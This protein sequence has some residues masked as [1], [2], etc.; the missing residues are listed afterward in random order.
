MNRRVPH[1]Y[2]NFIG[3]ILEKHGF[4][5]FNEDAEHVHY[6]STGPFNRNLVGAE[7]ILALYDKGGLDDHK[8]PQVID[9]LRKATDVVNLHTIYESPGFAAI[10]VEF[11]LK[12]Q[13]DG[14]YIGSFNDLEALNEYLRRKATFIEHQWSQRF[15]PVPS[16]VAERLQR[17]RDGVENL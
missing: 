15:G 16:D 3:P 10:A 12:H 7:M 9:T 13:P 4:E 14:S 2:R 5:V 11:G 17:M 6:R 8:D 1:K